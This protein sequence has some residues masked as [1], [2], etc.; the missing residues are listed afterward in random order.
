MMFTVA[1][2]LAR[3]YQPPVL[4]WEEGVRRGPYLKDV[5]DM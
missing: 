3:P 2:N 5:I 1:R 4:L